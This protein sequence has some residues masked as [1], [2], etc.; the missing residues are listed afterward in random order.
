MLKPFVPIKKNK[1]SYTGKMIPVII[2]ILSLSFN[3]AFLIHMITSHPAHSEAAEYHMNLNLSE[4]QK[5][6][7]EPIRLKMHRENEA[8]KKQIMKCQAKLMA[9]LKTEPV[10]KEAINRCIENISDLQKKIQLNTVEEIIRIRKYMSTEQCNCL[11]DNLGTAMNQT[12]KPCNCPHCRS[13]KK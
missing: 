4:E 13:H 5:K 3:I 9:A 10:D 12:T 8:V 7:M 11:I 6:L 2:F 1:K